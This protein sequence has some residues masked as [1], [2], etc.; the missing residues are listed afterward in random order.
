[1]ELY[2]FTYKDEN[3]GPMTTDNID[4]LQTA[5]KN[6]SDHERAVGALLDRM[7]FTLSTA[8]GKSLLR[9][10]SA[11]VNVDYF[12]LRKCLLV[13]NEAPVEAVT[14]EPD[15]RSQDIVKLDLYRHLRELPPA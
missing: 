2:S 14:D 9:S 1:M 11:G 8:H 12:T 13:Y 4:Q 10:L 15:E 3:G 7:G 6:L 5:L